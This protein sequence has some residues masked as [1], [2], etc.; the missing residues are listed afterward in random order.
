[1]QGG[2]DCAPAFVSGP[3]PGRSLTCQDS[4]VKRDIQPEG[5]PTF[6]EKK[7]IC[8]LIFLALASLNRLQSGSDAAV[9]SFAAIHWNTFT[10]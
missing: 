10:L 2:S 1:M 5:L 4:P 8:S 6:S 3:A 7:R 9:I